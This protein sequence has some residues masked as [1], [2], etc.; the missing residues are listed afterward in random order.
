LWIEREKIPLPL[1]QPPV[2][3]NWLL[4]TALRGE[5]CI[6]CKKHFTRVH[7]TPCGSCGVCQGCHSSFVPPL[8]MEDQLK[9][10]IRQLTQQVHIHHNTNLQ[11]RQK[12]AHQP[13]QQF[14]TKTC[15]ASLL[16]TEDDEKACKVCMTNE[17]NTLLLPCCHK[18]TCSDCYK[19]LAVKK[20]PL[21]RAPIKCIVPI[22]T[23]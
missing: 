19:G 8:S 9:R 13:L 14:L 11:L 3:D 22:F 15:N 20:C 23:A 17:S 21:C 18:V 10:Q 16:P 5:R 1:I 2:S 4:T 6:K 7:R 12:L